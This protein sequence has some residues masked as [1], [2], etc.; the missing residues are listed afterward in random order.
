[1]MTA[2]I[3]LCTYQGARFLS[4]QLASLEGQTRLPD[5]IYLYDDGSRDGTTTVLKQFAARSR[6]PV[7]ILPFTGH[8]G[9]NGG[10]MALLQA[11]EEDLV[12]FCDQDDIWAPHKLE[13]F[14]ACAARMPL[15]H[16]RPCV[17]HCEA[18]LMAADGHL[19]PQT[20]SDCLGPRTRPPEAFSLLGHNTVQ[21]CTCGVNAVMREWNRTVP[22]VCLNH[23]YYDQW[24]ALCAAFLGEIRFLPETLVYYRQHENNSVGAE[25]PGLYERFCLVRSYKRGA[26][27]FYA[28]QK[29]MTERERRRFRFW[30]R[31]G[32]CAPAASALLKQPC[33]LAAWLLWGVNDV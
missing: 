5:H 30:L 17:I 20:M 12:L 29:R 14:L 24:F 9:V 4:E 3:V 25:K 19:L 2:A 26:D 8:R 10:M 13:T 6:C 33:R 11:T 32:F 23:C 21:G 15:W 1:M 7:T 31:H 27:F 28:F 18:R 16:K 22:L